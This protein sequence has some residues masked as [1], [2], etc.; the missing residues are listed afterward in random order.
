MRPLMI[1]CALVASSAQ[2]GY[3]ERGPLPPTCSLLGAVEV[4][5]VGT[6]I[7]ADDPEQRATDCGR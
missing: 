5:F 2:P 6:L 4:T 3:P 1:A 7:A